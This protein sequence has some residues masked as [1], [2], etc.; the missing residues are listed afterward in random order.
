[1]KPN[2]CQPGR[3]V[4]IEWPE[5]D[6]GAAKLDASKITSGPIDRIDWTN[7]FDQR[8]CSGCIFHVFNRVD[9]RTYCRNPDS[10]E[11]GSF[12]LNNDS[13]DCFTERTRS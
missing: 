2:S 6:L 13:C 11:N 1:M 3:S 12:K 5:I 7:L 8:T 10:W 4:N 9:H